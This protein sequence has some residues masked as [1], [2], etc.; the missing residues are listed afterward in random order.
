MDVL[1]YKF[2][3]NV[4]SQFS[5]FSALENSEGY[6]IGFLREMGSHLPK[7]ISNRNIPKNDLI[8]EG[9]SD[10]QRL[11][12]VAVMSGETLMN[13]IEEKSKK[14]QERRQNETP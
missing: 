12:E 11:G 10:E 7:E 9:D 5:S 4:G 6:D 13:Q 14:A 3:R 1:K 2:L 8:D